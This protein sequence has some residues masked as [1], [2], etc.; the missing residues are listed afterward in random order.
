V[1]EKDAHFDSERRLIM[2]V[3]KNNGAYSPIE[4]GSYMIETHFDDFLEKR[5]HLEAELNK[6][7]VE[8]EI[9]PIEYYRVLLNIGIA[10]LASRVGISSRKVKKHLSPDHFDGINL[11]VL[12][13]Y[14]DVFRIP[15]ANL[16]QL[17][18]LQEPKIGIVQEQTKNQ[19]ITITNLRKL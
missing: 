3:E 1:K 9:S 12:K 4:T 7:L 11:R 13:K 17:F 16:F 18:D 5:K 19:F 14:A 8:S 2:Y 10:D 15:L 6:K